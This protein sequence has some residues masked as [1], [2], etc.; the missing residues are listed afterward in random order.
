MKIAD[1][2]WKQE[3]LTP[4]SAFCISKT[5]PIFITIAMLMIPTIVQA[6]EAEGTPTPDLTQG[7]LHIV[8]GRESLSGLANRYYNDIYAWPAIWKATNAKAEAGESGFTYINSPEYLT[9]GQYLWIPPIEQLPQ[10][11][12]DYVPEQA[13]LQPLTEAM[14]TDLTTYIETVRQRYAIPGAA[15]MVVEGNQIRLAKGFGI[16]EVGQPNSVT[17]DT[18]FAIAS[19][20]KPL[21]AMLMASLVNDGIISWT[22]PI[23]DI[24][25]DFK[26][27]E[28]EHTAYTKTVQIRHLL[29]MSAGLS[30][31]DLVW[32][33]TNLSA[34][35]L[36]ESLIEAKPW[37]NAG[38]YFLYHNQSVAT[39]GYL[40]ALADGAEYGQLQ[41]HYID[42]MQTRLF[43]PISMTQATLS[44]TD[45]LQNPNH[46]TPHDFTMDGQVIP[47][48]H[49]V[50]TSIMPAGG[51]YASA[52]DMARFLITQMQYGI[53]PEGVS[54]I[55]PNHISQ[56]MTPQIDY[57][58]DRSAYGL[59]W[60]IE[61]YRGV[62]IVWHDGDVLGF[63]ALVAIFPEANVGLVILSNRIMGK[64]FA[65]SVLYRLAEQLY[66]LNQNYADGFYE[67]SY[68]TV[69]EALNNVY[70][71]TNSVITPTSVM[72][73]L[74]NYEGNWQVELRDT[75]LWVTR[76][77]YQWQL[78]LATDGSTP[79]YM[80]NNGFGIGS[81]LEFVEHADGHITMEF[82]LSGGSIGVYEKLP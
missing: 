19:T 82:R 25:P 3:F 38:D 6:Q 64:W 78:R 36:I 15:V 28:S 45:V 70:T 59:G 53:T 60:F 50:D 68:Q 44:I 48:H 65:Y 57:V 56:T 66:G 31:D 33:G 37:V 71:N 8:A 20:T 21:N 26:V 79:Y 67:E 43:N 10:W 12:A 23:T 1:I 35:A 34:E 17:P 14:L 16:R 5:F 58:T 42:L 61:D 47:T 13:N 72:T 2:R 74:G 80:I 40:G 63:K 69:I 22:Q 51:V 46:A 77:P 24:W 29:S 18:V 27:A 30:R 75:S 41:T 52:N 62:K 81:P 39:A 4:L 76:G 9:A 54:L 7:Q 55:S 73:Y 49:H 32:S 11:L